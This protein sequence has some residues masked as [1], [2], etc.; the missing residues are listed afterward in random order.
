MFKGLY[1][2]SDDGSGTGQVN[3]MTVSNCVFDSIY[4]YA[5]EGNYVFNLTS[6]FNSYRDVGNYYNGIGDPQ[7]Y[8]INFRENSEGCASITDQFDRTLADNNQSVP[9]INGNSHTAAL[10]SGHEFR[11]GLYQQAGGETYTLTYGQTNQLVG[12]NLMFGDLSYNK[13]VKYLINRNSHTRAGM[14]T[15]TYDPDS[16]EYNLD[17][18][19][20]ETGNIGVV[21]SLTNAGSGVLSLRYTSDSSQTNTFNITLAE[22][23]LKTAW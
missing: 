22:E 7:E 21:F 20:S 19:S 11:L 17:D 13:R 1:L 12:F 5:I 23:Y 14:L 4:S 9:W 6:T 3:T 2:C 16:L 10:H 15:I 8:I 18:D